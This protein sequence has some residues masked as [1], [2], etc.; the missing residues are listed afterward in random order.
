[1]LHAVGAAEVPGLESRVKEV[2]ARGGLAKA[3]V[4]AMNEG[5]KELGAKASALCARLADLRRQRKVLERAI[6]SVESDLDALLDE[7]GDAELETPSGTLKRVTENGVR[8][9]VLE[10]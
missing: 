10:V 2:A 5:R 3:A 1:M 7:V 8:R 9:F 6:A 4:E